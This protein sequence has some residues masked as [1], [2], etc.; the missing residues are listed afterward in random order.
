MSQHAP[1]FAL[2]T[3]FGLADPYVGQMKAALHAAAPH[4]PILDVSHDVPPFIVATGAFFLAS[5]RKYF[6][7]GTIFICVVDPG[8]GSKRGLVCLTNGVHTLL[9]PDN[10]LLDLAR[11]D[12][13]KTGPVSARHIIPPASPVAATFHG[14]DILVP[15]ACALAKG[16]SPTELGPE[17]EYP[18][19]L[20]SWATAGVSENTIVCTVLHVDRFGNCI[21][22]LI[23]EAHAVLESEMV[24]EM[25]N[26]A[27][28]PLQKGTHYA[29]LSPHA[30]GV[31]PGSQGFCEIAF[32]N[33]SA[34]QRLSICSGAVCRIIRR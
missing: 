22:N 28:I 27:V 14:R 2:L 12:M 24:L 16:A 26:G 11:R 7:P 5:S 1:A 33:L 19:T 31:L 17:I 13:L 30:P 20:P 3:D 6:A 25:P 32:N 34:A 15:A 8:V 21:L 23:S 9:G 4:V 18:R 29:E 10:G